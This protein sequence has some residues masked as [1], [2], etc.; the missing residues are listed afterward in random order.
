MLIRCVKILI[1]ISLPVTVL[2][3]V[4]GC[5]EGTTPDIITPVDDPA[6]AM[7]AQAVLVEGTMLAALTDL[8]NQL[9]AG[10]ST[11]DSTRFL[12]QSASDVLTGVIDNTNG[13]VY[14]TGLINT[15]GMIVNVQ[16]DEFGDLVGTFWTNRPE[17]D[18]ALAEPSLEIG[19]PLEVNLDWTVLY[20][21][22]VYSLGAVHGV[23]FAMLDLDSLFTRNV[24]F[25]GIDT[26]ADREF[27]ALDQNGTILFSTIEGYSGSIFTDSQTY[28][29]DQVSVAES[30]VSPDSLQGSSTLDLS[31]SPGGEGDRYLG[32]VHMPLVNSRFWVL[33]A[34][35]PVE[36]TD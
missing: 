18:D 19:A 12:S 2:L 25:A 13:D 23:L 9:N 27:F 29:E 5:Q 34:S 24:E 8:Q 22:T 17:V 7:I 16:P 36:D 14:A 32:W 1:Q 33:A 28:T 10:Q 31:N 35:L 11:L 3:M 4:I 26:V 20:T 15:S 21:R 30:M 6:E